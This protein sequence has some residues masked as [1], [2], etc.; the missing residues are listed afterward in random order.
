MRGSEKGVRGARGSKL[1]GTLGPTELVGI[2][3]LAPTS[4]GDPKTYPLITIMP[5][6]H[7]VNCELG[8]K[9][10]SKGRD[11]WLK[12]SGGHPKNWPHRW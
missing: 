7:S 12:R 5:Y 11:S 3:K 1:G 10:G 9:A 8:E 2:P 4:G 6:L